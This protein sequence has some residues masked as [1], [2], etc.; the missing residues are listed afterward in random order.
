MHGPIQEENGLS[1]FWRVRLA[2]SVSSASPSRV[3]DVRGVRKNYGKVEAL[4]GVDLAVERGTILGLLG[5]NGAGKTTLVRVLATLLR[6]D[7][8]TATVAGLDVLRDAAALRAVIGLA[9]QYAAVDEHLTGRENIALA[10]RLH[11]IPK[12]EALRRADALLKRFD[13]EEAGGR[14]TSTYSGGM[15][16]R[17]DLAASLVAEPDVIF[18][19]EPTTGLDPRSRLALWGII[20]DLR[21]E[22]RTILLTT[23]YLEEAD[24]LCDKIAVVDHG[25]I[26]AEGTATE[27]KQKVG[28]DVVEIA[29]RDVD[30]MQRALA[31]FTGATADEARLR[32]SLPA[33]DGSRSLADAI[34][35]LD[36]AKIDALDISLRRP[37]LDDVFL[38]LTGRAAVA[39]EASA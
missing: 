11:H 4:R 8:G 19:D 21:R 9:G 5:P 38:K 2:R 27:L 3:I 28:G 16:R 30:S 22:G 12:A 15:R 31:A 23:Q 20:E 32:V 13:L 18:L 10:A 25:V 37:T 1:F 35:K 26:I 33:P 34:R 7:A 17:L 6:P 29:L 24:R 36:A 14:K 39:E